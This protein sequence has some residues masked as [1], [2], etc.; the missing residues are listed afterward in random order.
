MLTRFPTFNQRY[1]SCKKQE[2]KIHP[3]GTE[4][5]VAAAEIAKGSST[6][7]T[8][9]AYSQSFN[10]SNSSVVIPQCRHSTLILDLP[11]LTYSC[12]IFQ[13]WLAS[14]PPWRSYEL[15]DFLPV[16]ILLKSGSVNFFSS[17]HQIWLPL[18]L[19]HYLLG[20]LSCSSLNVTF[21]VKHSITS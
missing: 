6:K 19:T 18:H 2:G 7:V 11:S 16:S 9:E 3:V 21:W 13:K 15:F 20:K 17:K 10:S 8:N 1:Y 5:T 12:P 4:A 14:S